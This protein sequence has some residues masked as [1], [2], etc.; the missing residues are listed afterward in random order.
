[1][2]SV[3]DVLLDLPF[4]PARRRSAE[5]RLEQ[6]V[7]DHGREA[8]IDLPL[9]PVPDPVYGRPH[10][11]VDAALRNAAEYAERV[12]VGVEQHL[13]RLLQIGAQEESPAIT[14]LEVGDLELGSLASDDRPIF[15]PIELK[16]LAGGESQRHEDAPA[17]GSLLEMAS[18][19]PFARERRN[20]IVRAVVAQRRQIGVQLQD[21]PLLLA[22]LAGLLPQHMRQ[23]VSK[24]IELARPVRQVEL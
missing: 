7:A 19:L 5:L 16:S 20:A 18:G 13:V 6:E 15:R 23:L 2:A 4:L 22:R 9:L 8:R 14:E 1:M 3:L 12:V 24:R 21:R 17:R 10:V 11:V